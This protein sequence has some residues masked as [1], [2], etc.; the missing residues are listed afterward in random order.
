MEREVKNHE[1]GICYCNKIP[2]IAHELAQSLSIISSYVKGC[3]ERVKKDNLDIKQL[4]TI[5][6]KINHQI[7]IM[8]D[9]IHCMI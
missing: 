3:N 6:E 7:Q 1:N 2:I 9:K 4:I 8:D 5:F